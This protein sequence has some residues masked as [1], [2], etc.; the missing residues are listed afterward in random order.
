MR[1]IESL[2]EENKAQL[3][4]RIKCSPKYVLQIEVAT[5]AAGSD[6]VLVFVRYS[7]EE[8]ILRKFMFCL[9]FSERDVFKAVNVYFTAGNIS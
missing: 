4:T 8:N 7:L 6:Q 2:S 9:P 5:D 1:W 3:L